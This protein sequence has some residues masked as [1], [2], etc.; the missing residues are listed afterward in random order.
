MTEILVTELEEWVLLRLEQRA[1]R[2][3]RSVED[4]TLEI[5]RETLEKEEAP[6]FGDFDI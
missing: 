6:R 4:E 2:N 1:V 3:G 5:L